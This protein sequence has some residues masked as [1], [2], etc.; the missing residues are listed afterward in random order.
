MLEVGSGIASFCQAVIAVTFRAKP[1]CLHRYYHTGHRCLDTAET[2]KFSHDPLTDITRPILLKVI[3]TSL[4]IYIPWSIDGSHSHLNVLGLQ[5][6]GG[7][8]LVTCLLCKRHS[9]RALWLKDHRKNLSVEIRNR[10][11]SMLFSHTHPL[12]CLCA[13]AGTCH[14]A[15]NPSGSGW[16]PCS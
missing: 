8:V 13:H 4:F 3:F 7:G 10:G 11:W 1:F 5:H 16:P 14:D 6:E 9:L 12:E 15:E 2:C